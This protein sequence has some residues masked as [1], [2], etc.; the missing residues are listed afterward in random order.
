MYRTDRPLGGGGY[1]YT[2]TSD[3]EDR[4]EQKITNSRKEESL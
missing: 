2:G 1:V 4:L 3:T